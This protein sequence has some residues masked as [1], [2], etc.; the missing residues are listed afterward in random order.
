MNRWSLIS[1]SMIMT[2]L[3][4]PARKTGGAAPGLKAVETPENARAA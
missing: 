2:H 4:W 3:A 1:C